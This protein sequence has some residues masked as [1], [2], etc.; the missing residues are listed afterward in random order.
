MV[1]YARGSR[2]SEYEKKKTVGRLNIFVLQR[3]TY[4]PPRDLYDVISPN[5]GLFSHI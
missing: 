4:L 1:Y 5:I 3:W 2:G